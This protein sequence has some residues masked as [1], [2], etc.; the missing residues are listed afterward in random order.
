MKKEIKWRTKKELEG[1]LSDRL[2]LIVNATTQDSSRFTARSILF[3]NAKDAYRVM[4][5][6]EKQEYRL[7]KS[8]FM[9]EE[10]VSHGWPHGYTHGKVNGWNIPQLGEMIR[11]VLDYICS[12]RVGNMSYGEVCHVVGVLMKGRA[13]RRGASAE[14][15]ARLNYVLKEGN[16]HF[17][18][19]IIGAVELALTDFKYNRQ[20]IKSEG[21]LDDPKSVWEELEKPAVINGDIINLEDARRMKG[22]AR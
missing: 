21:S 10:E 16:E 18:N 9:L 12:G 20:P 11:L 22:G 7:K 13:T 15:K 3:H 2:W 14:F 19:I 17:K 6:D 8:D 1:E 4:P 5:E